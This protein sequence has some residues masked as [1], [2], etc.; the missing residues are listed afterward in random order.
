MMVQ[1]GFTKDALDPVHDVRWYNAHAVERKSMLE[2]C[3][4]NP[5]QLTKTPNCVN[6][7]QAAR[8][9]MALAPSTPPPPLPEQSLAE[10]RKQSLNE[11]SKQ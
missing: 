8:E 3:H 1:T 7:E 2:K 9:A 10:M 6:A 5:G 4:N 11:K